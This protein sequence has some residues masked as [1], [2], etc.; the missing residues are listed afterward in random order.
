MGR[1]WRD[2]AAIALPP[3][4]RHSTTAR[5]WMTWSSAKPARIVASKL[6]H[7]TGD[8]AEPICPRIVRPDLFKPTSIWLRDV[9]HCPPVFLRHAIGRRTIDPARANPRST[10]G[11][12]AT[13]RDWMKVRRAA[14]LNSVASTFDPQVAIPIAANEAGIAEGRQRSSFF[15]GNPRCDH[16][17]SRPKPVPQV[18]FREYV[19]VIR[20]QCFSIR[21][22]ENPF[23]PCCQ[24]RI[25]RQSPHGLKS[26]RS[27]WLEPIGSS[28]VWQ[29]PK[30]VV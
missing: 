4:F 24:S 9:G 7:D 5:S 18:I 27:S 29:S 20:G 22:M 13:R 17:R 30:L 12:P 21:S 3:G 8:S 6:S 11:T 10:S 16:A 25:Q 26:M 1:S 19:T 2:A 23:R 14:S 15:R 28:S